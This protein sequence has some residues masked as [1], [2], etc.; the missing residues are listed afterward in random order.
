MADEPLLGAEFA[1]NTFRVNGQM[2][3]AGEQLARP[4]GLTVAR[5]QVLGAVLRRPLNAAGIAREMGI[6]RQAVQRVANRLIEDGLLQALPNPAH[7]RSPLLSPTPEGVA[8]VQKIAP[9]QADFSARL[10]EAFGYERFRQLIDDLAAFSE[11]LDEVDP[12]PG[13]T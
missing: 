2:L 11:V 6:S 1:R 4:V 13:P 7:N 12:W 3:A 10:V 5:W 9:Q 8:A